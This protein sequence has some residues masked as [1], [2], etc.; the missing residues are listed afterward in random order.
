MGRW[1]R[2]RPWPADLRRRSAKFTEPGA[3]AVAQIESRSMVFPHPRC[4]SAVRRASGGRKWSGWASESRQGT[5]LREQQAR[6]PAEATGV[7]MSDGLT[8]GPG[9]LCRRLPIDANCGGGKATAADV[10][11]FAVVEPLCVRLSDVTGALRL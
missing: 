8:R 1:R 7:V 9:S 10:G 6:E 5:R 4:T 11:L 3:N 2:P